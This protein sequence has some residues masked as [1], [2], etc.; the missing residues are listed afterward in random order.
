[1]KE[2]N[3]ARVS[4]MRKR[5]SNIPLGPATVSNNDKAHGTL[6]SQWMVGNTL[7]MVP[8]AQ[9]RILDGEWVRDG[10]EAAKENVLVALLQIIMDLEEN[11]AAGSDYRNRCTINMSFGGNAA[12][13]LPGFSEQQR[14]SQRSN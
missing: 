8:K 7:G 4:L 13:A 12:L 9:L 2:F 3:G 1:M 5:S 14:K 6:I 11:Q 10:P